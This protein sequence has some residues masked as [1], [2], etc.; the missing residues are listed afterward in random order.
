MRSSHKLQGRARAQ[1]IAEA[2]AWEWGFSLAE[3]Q[4]LSRRRTA[5]KARDAATRALRE[6]T[7]LSLP[8][9]AQIIGWADHASVLNSLQRS[10][11]SSTS[12]KV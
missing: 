4:Q 1:N 8:E 10:A 11:Q 7:D 5:V 2:V 6:Q 9:I 3:L 12:D